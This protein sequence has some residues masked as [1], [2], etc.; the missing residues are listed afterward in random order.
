MREDMASLMIKE[1][2]FR[3]VVESTIEPWV[4]KEFVKGHFTS[5]DNTKLAYYYIVNPKEKASVVMCH[6]YCEFF[7]KYYE[8][9]YIFYNMGYSVFF[10]EHR[11]YGF[12]ERAVPELDYVYVRDYDDYVEDFHEYMKQIVT[13]ESK[14]KQY[15]LFAHSMGGCISTL[16]MEKYLNYF[17]CAILSSPM[18]EM[19]LGKFKPWQ[20]ELISGI[21]GV[22]GQDKKLASGQKRF[23]GV[24]VWEKSSSMS[25]ARYDYQFDKRL[26]VPEYTTYGGTFAWAKASVRA[27]KKCLR[28]A[29]VIETP[30]L[31]L[32]AGNDR[33]VD[34]EGHRKFVD[35]TH[36]T[37]YKIFPE[38]KHELFNATQDIR[39]EYF[40]EIFNYLDE[41]LE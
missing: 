15:V 5:F 6:G 34:N 16:F 18:H 2:D 29:A 8:L 25:K 26:S 36:N 30:I 31:L 19:K 38:S 23:D 20:V 28:N 14:S 4:E 10:V 35:M 32:E 27:S 12:S 39:E 1:D 9:A 41:I 37:T 24:N 33:L 3:G 7:P 13:K 22:F 17:K 40:E 21:C 11:G